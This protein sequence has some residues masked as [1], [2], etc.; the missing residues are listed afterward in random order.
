MRTQH[1]HIKRHTSLPCPTK[2]TSALFYDSNLVTNCL[3]PEQSKPHAIWGHILLFKHTICWRASEF[4]IL[5]DIWIE[6]KHL[7]KSTKPLVVWHRST[8]HS[9]LNIDSYRL[10]KQSFL[11]NHTSPSAYKIV[12]R[13]LL[14]KPRCATFMTFPLP[15][16]RT[17]P[18]E[19]GIRLVQH[20]LI[21]TNPHW[22]NFW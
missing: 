17:V 5:L 4:M 15:T 8:S 19:K 6:K 18:S 16:W 10:D 1:C 21:V 11:L 20:G 9:F 3:R 12:P 13:V 22:L 14:F 2:A 7:K